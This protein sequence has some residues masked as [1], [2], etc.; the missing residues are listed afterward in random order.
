MFDGKFR[1]PVD[2]A[3]TP[4][5]NGLRRTGLTPDHLTALGLLVAVGA[6]VA[7]GF[8]ELRLGLVLVVLADQL[9]RSV[10]DMYA[11]A[12]GPSLAQT[13]NKVKNTFRKLCFLKQLRH[14]LTNK[15]RPL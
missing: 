6:A 5:G 13:L 11:G 3:V 7:I 1:A 8:G 12:I 9:G 2:K 4:L 10:G 14:K 15:R